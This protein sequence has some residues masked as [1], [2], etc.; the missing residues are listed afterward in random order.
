MKVCPAAAKLYSRAAWIAAGDG[1]AVVTTLGSRD[2]KNDHATSANSI[3]RLWMPVAGL[4]LRDDRPDR[5][6]VAGDLAE[7]LLGLAAD[8]ANHAL[9][10]G[11]A[12]LRNGHDRG[13]VEHHA[14][15]AHV[16]QRI[17]GAEVDRQ[18]AREVT[19]EKAEHEPPL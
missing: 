13:L 3:S 7:H 6:D 14:L 1:G 4:E 12:F 8:R 5:L 19:T 18:I 17:G 2:L 10:V 16:D 15:A 9:A 11:A